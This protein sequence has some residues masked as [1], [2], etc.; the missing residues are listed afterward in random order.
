MVDDVI[1]E[2]N[3]GKG[4]VATTNRLD[5]NVYLERLGTDWA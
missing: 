1:P 2:H 3:L 4:A 5:T